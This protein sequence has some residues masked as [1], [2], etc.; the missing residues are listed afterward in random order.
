MSGELGLTVV[1]MMHAVDEDKVRALY[2]MGENP[3]LSDPNP[4]RCPLGRNSHPA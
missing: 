3:A 2:I 1:E 4:D